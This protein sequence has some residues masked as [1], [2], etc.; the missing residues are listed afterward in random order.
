VAYSYARY[1]GDGNTSTYTFQFPYINTSDIKAR[2]NGV[3]VTFTLLNASTVALD[4]TPAAGA[5]VEIR[6]VTQ[7]DTVPV[8]FTDGSVL[9]ERDLDLLALYD[10]YIAQ[11]TSD[12]VEESIRLDSQGRY[13]AKGKRI[14]NVANPVAAGDAVNKGTLDYEYPAVAIVAANK[15]NIYT[16]ASDLGVPSPSVNDLGS[17][18][19]E[20]ED[21]PTPETSRIVKVAENI[22]AIVGIGDNL[23]IVLQAPT[24]AAEAQAS[25]EDAQESEEAA[26]ASETVATTKASEAAASAELADGYRAT[27]EAAK[28]VAVSAKDQAVASASAAATSASNAAASAS[29]ALASEGAAA[30]SEANAATSA[31]EAADLFDQFDDR[32]LGPKASDP[33]TDNDGNALVEGALYWNTSSN[34]FRAYTGSGWQA[35]GGLPSQDG[36]AGKFLK[37]DGAEAEWAVIPDPQPATPDD[38]GLVYGSTPTDTVEVYE[39]WPTSYMVIAPNIGGYWTYINPSN[40]QDVRPGSSSVL[41]DLVAVADAGDPVYVEYNGTTYYLGTYISGGVNHLPGGGIWVEFSYDNT[42]GSGFT[43]NVNIATY[44]FSS[45]SSASGGNTSL[46]Y[47]S[48]GDNGAKN[49]SIGYG[50]GSTITSGFNNTVIGYN[51]EPSSGTVNNEATLGNSD[52]TKTRLFGALAINDQ[53][54]TSGQVLTSNGTSAP[55]WQTPSAPPVTSV[56]GQTGTV[57]LDAADV[58]AATAAQGALADSAVQPGDLATVATSGSYTDLSNKPTLGTAAATDST[59]YATAAQGS[60]ADT[61]YGWGNHASAGYALSSSLGT[62]AGLNSV[63]SSEISNGAVTVDKFADVIDLGGLS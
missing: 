45:P 3:D 44:V 58:G 24:F 47:N 48:N 49:T 55:T 18:T 37:S 34:E 9:L 15:D 17:V 12:A 13:D 28:D 33:T 40:V 20:I 2:V 22:D 19:D 11:E 53:V 5:I 59:A 6:R 63:S 25:A 16:V 32:F 56:N 23:E 38:D 21:G 51:A 57:V 42:G 31:Q 39:G 52:T 8:N 10:L 1:T 61:A 4:A 7:K 60:N 50:A 14:I 35:F 36:A 27:T 26:A 29:A 46:G 30:T 43:S 54:G 41:A 62:L